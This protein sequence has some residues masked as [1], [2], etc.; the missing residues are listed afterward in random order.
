[1]DEGALRRPLV[2]VPAA[3]AETD[4]A[5]PPRYRVWPA[6]ASGIRMLLPDKAL[7]LGVTA[8]RPARFGRIRWLGDKRTMV[9]HDLDAAIGDCRVDELVGS[10][11]FASFGPDSAAEARNRGY[12]PCRWCRPM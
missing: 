5:H 6:S 12:R 8:P 11:R 2:R 7:R 4:R 1:M 9:V 10:G 3:V